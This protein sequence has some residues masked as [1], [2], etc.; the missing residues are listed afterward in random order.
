[1]DP[2]DADGLWLRCALHAHTTNSDGELP[3]DKLV[4][5]YDW[6]GYDVLAITDHWHV[7]RFEHEG[8]LVPPSAELSGRIEG[9]LEE[10]DVLAYGIDELPEARE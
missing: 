2:F 10:P 3:P 4:R 1:V 9:E 8:V 7:T 6:A 5:H